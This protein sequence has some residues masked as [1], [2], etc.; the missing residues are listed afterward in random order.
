MRIVM[1]LG[2]NALGSNLEEQKEAIRN[3]AH[4]IADLMQEGHELV[5][6]HGNGPQVGKIK[7]AM[8]EEAPLSTC[9]AM[10]QAYIGLD[11]QNV[12][13]EELLNRGIQKSVISFIT[14]SIVERDYEAFNHPD[15]PIGSFFDEKHAKKLAAKGISVMEDAGR[16]YRQV[17]PSPKPVRI[18]ELDAIRTLFDKGH[19]VIACGG[20]GVPVVQ[21]GNH[22]EAVEAVID[23]DYASAC[24]A[25]E[26]DADWLILLTG[27]EKV[28]VNYGKPDQEWLSVITVDQ[29]IKYIG[30]NQFAPGSMLPKIKA[31]IEFATSKPGSKTLITLLE[32]AKAGIHNETGTVICA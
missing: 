1:A 14:Q 2:G 10:S 27:V 8:K 12:I 7:L 15:K 25:E 28:A 11:M 20:G 13:R 4:V 5:L 17:V 29:A 31:A 26:L 22:L 6:T 18:V 19:L 9:G 24:L 3:V 23:K 21:S 16:G 30:E 32:K